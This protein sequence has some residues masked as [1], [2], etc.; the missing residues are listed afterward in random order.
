M[1]PQEKIKHDAII[2]R[3]KVVENKQ[4]PFAAMFGSMM[5]YVHGN[6]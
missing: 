4:V 5:M 2:E 6:N 1:S 3:I